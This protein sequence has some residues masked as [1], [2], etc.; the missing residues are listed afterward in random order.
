MDELKA[1]ELPVIADSVVI[2]K[3]NE[4][5]IT[6]DL[7]GLIE[8]ERAMDTLKILVPP[9]KYSWDGQGFYDYPQG[10]RFWDVYKR[11]IYRRWIVTEEG[12]SDLLK[13]SFQIANANNYIQKKKLVD[14]YIQILKLLPEHLR[15]NS[16]QQIMK[17]VANDAQRNSD[18]LNALSN[19]ITEIDK[20]ESNNVNVINIL[21]NFGVKNQNDGIPFINYISTIVSKFDKTQQYKSV[22]QLRNGY[23]WYFDQNL[24]TLKEATD[25]YVQL[26]SQIKIDQQANTLIQYYNVFLEKNNKRSDLIKQIDFEYQQEINAVESKF[27]TDQQEALMDFEVNKAKKEKLRIKSLLGVGGGILLVVLIA[28]FLAFLSIQRSV[29]KMEEKIIKSKE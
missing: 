1:A 7:T 16:L 10:K 20:T 23:Y 25:L 13:S 19:V 15:I 18:I 12:I 6:E 24:E 11:E 17:N 29:R 21:S 26:L 4:P 8:F 9:S 5:K 3:A 14:S 2:A 22:E 28:T 27:L